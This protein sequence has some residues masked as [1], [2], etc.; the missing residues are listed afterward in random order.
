MAKKLNQA[1][2]VQ[3][4]ILN[5]K[6][7][8]GKVKVGRPVGYFAA[9]EQP[10]SSDTSASF[11]W[12]YRTFNEVQG[13]CTKYDPMIS[14]H[15]RGYDTGWCTLT[16]RQTDT[17]NEVLD[18]KFNW[19]RTGGCLDGKFTTCSGYNYSSFFAPHYKHFR[20]TSK[21]VVYSK[22]NSDR[23]NIISPIVPSG[24][25]GLYTVEVFRE[26]SGPI[27][28]D[29]RTKDS[30]A[31]FI[32]GH[33]KYTSASSPNNASEFVH[34]IPANKWTRIDI[35]HYS[36]FSSGK[37]NIGGYLGNQ[38]D[39]WRL[40]PL[41]SGVQAFYNSFSRRTPGEFGKWSY[42]LAYITPP[43][44]PDTRYV[45]IDWRAPN[46][47]A[48][49]RRISLE[50]TNPGVQISG[51][52]RLPGS[53]LIEVRSRAVNIWGDFGEWHT[54]SG[55]IS[56]ASNA[57]T[58]LAPELRSITNFR[59]DEG[60]GRF[61]FSFNPSTGEEWRD[62]ILVSGMGQN[63]YLFTSALSS[64]VTQGQ[65]RL[66]SS[67]PPTVVASGMFLSLVSPYYASVGENHIVEKVEGPTIY[68]REPITTNWGIGIPFFVYQVAKTTSSTK[69]DL[70]VNN[71]NTYYFNI[72]GRNFNGG[73]SALAEDSSSWKS[74]SV[75]ITAS[76][77]IGPGETFVGKNYV[78]N[79]SFEFP[80][81]SRAYLTGGKYVGGGADG[82][83]NPLNWWYVTSGW[84]H[85]LHNVNPRGGRQALSFGNLIFTGKVEAGIGLH[86]AIKQDI[87]SLNWGQN[88]YV[89]GFCHSHETNS[90]LYKTSGLVAVRHELW[91]YDADHVSQVDFQ[92][93]SLP[94]G[95]VFVSSGVT[96][97]PSPRLIGTDLNPDNYYKTEI[98]HQI[99]VTSPII[100]GS[101]TRRPF[102]RIQIYSPPEIF[103]YQNQSGVT[104]DWPGVLQTW[105]DDISLS[106]LDR[107]D[108]ILDDDV[109]ST[110]LNVEGLR[111]NQGAFT[112]EGDH[113]HLDFIHGL[114]VT[115]RR[116][117]PKP[118]NKAAAS[119]LGSFTISGY[120][121]IPR[122]IRCIPEAASLIGS[123]PGHLANSSL[124]AGGV[125]VVPSGR[126][127][128]FEY[129]PVKTYLSNFGL[130][131]WD[132]PEREITV[133]GSSVNFFYPSG[134]STFGNPSFYFDPG[135]H[136]V[137]QVSDILYNIAG[138]GTTYRESQRPIVA[139]WGDVKVVN[140][141]LDCRTVITKNSSTYV[142]DAATSPTAYWHVCNV[143]IYEIGSAYVA[144]GVNISVTPPSTNGY[145]TIGGLMMFTTDP[146]ST[147]R[148]ASLP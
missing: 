40:P 90:F 137:A 37:L 132:N 19:L 48:S 105:V 6:V 122:L 142:P 65:T 73:I 42:C 109:D 148:T 115:R 10:T 103:G 101:F 62:F 67:I 28:L 93:G 2:Q 88:Y 112:N 98:S 41:P 17:S 52:F 26:I 36:P 146:N 29:L 66:F 124:M 92:Y 86:A 44:D 14:G 128:M 63:N 68:L 31:I 129:R 136:G 80:K 45:D 145:N 59:V 104:N 1:E 133:G 118:I 96:F 116:G 50:V 100:T 113:L 49:W 140:L 24:Y 71:S 4:Q 51:V 91:H 87:D 144:S 34:D 22:I 35:S 89:K 110:K 27:K 76:G 82:I 58:D 126:A 95:A 21:D 38:V 97:T 61:E 108:S 135:E 3:R 54:I 78:R 43:N 9:E 56:S 30:L 94:P 143:K 125:L 121:D 120:Q 139:K 60:I 119:S 12:A 102:V 46:L 74:A 114:G 85:L 64:P 99:Q 107:H 7:E 84:G 5:A 127:L 134:G 33:N 55:L 23:G 47:F 130:P 11:Q 15:N 53:E 20:S 77:L 32:S 111:L 123:T 75:S 131:G 79:G 8:L 16:L 72:A 147:Y 70:V 18:A 69:F 81:Y 13:R 39:S 106:K 57:R 25:N 117:N 141:F 83:P 138:D